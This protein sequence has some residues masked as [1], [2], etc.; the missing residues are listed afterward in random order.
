MQS[1]GETAGAIIET[2]P[3]PTRRFESEKREA[4][5]QDGMTELSAED[6]PSGPWDIVARDREAC[7]EVRAP[8]GEH[9]YIYYEDE[10]ERRA[11]LKRF[12]RHQ[13]AQIALAIARLP[14]KSP[15]SR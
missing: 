1:G 9:I 13:A 8:S 14:D 6:L 4:S 7:L 5:V 11:I 10:P 12:S 2:D 15:A 3:T